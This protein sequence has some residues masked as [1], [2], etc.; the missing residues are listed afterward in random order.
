MIRSDN[1]SFVRERVVQKSIRR[2]S[3]I[4]WQFLQKTLQSFTSDFVKTDSL[5]CTRFI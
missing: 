1:D 5:T 4:Y 3:F 2:D